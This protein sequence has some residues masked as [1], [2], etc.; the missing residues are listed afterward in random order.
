MAMLKEKK[1]KKI[2]WILILCL[3]SE[4]NTSL[5]E[6]VA[7]ISSIPIIKRS[8]NQNKAFK[9]I[10]V[11]E[12]SFR[13]VANKFKVLEDYD[14]FFNDD[15]YCYFIST[16]NG[17]YSLK[18]SNTYRG[19]DEGDSFFFLP[20]D[21]ELAKVD[22]LTTEVVI[23]FG[24]IEAD[25]EDIKEL[26]K[27]IQA[28]RDIADSMGSSSYEYINVVKILFD[29]LANLKHDSRLVTDSILIKRMNN[30]QINEFEYIYKGERN[31]SDYKYLINFRLHH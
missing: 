4:A 14:D 8:L 31:F 28:A 19:L 16:Q 11:A 26:K 30:K 25:G 3:S 6:E 7:K 22:D 5:L 12:Q 2:F 10:W 13:F 1:M 21:R 15:I 29:S 27:I 17:I 18:L 20:E 9:E 23:D 24:I